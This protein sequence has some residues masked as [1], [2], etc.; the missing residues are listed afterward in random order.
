MAIS[1]SNLYSMLVATSNQINIVSGGGGGGSLPTFRN[2]IINGD[3]RIDQRNCG[4]A[5][6]ITQDGVYD[7]PDR[8]MAV[9]NTYSSSPSYTFQQ[10]TLSATDMNTLG[11]ITNSVRLT[12]TNGNT[13][14]NS[15]GMVGMQYILEGFYIKDLN[16]GTV[17]GNNISVN[18][19]MKTNVIGNHN[20]ALTNN[21]KNTSYVATFNVGVSNTW[22]NVKFTVPAPPSTSDWDTSSNVG[23]RL[24]I[25]ATCLGYLTGNSNTWRN[26]E[27]NLT[28]SN[29][30]SS[31]WLTS[32]NYVEITG[33][34]LEIGSNMTP[35]EIRPLPIELGLCRRYFEKNFPF[36]TLPTSSQSNT[37]PGDCMYFANLTGMGYVSF[38]DPKCTIPTIDF[39]NPY[40]NVGNVRNSAGSNYT[41]LANQISTVGVGVRT[42]DSGLNNSLGIFNWK[43]NCE[44]K[45]YD[46]NPS[47]GKVSWIA[48]LQSSDAGGDQ[49]TTVCSTSDGGI[50]AAGYYNSTYTLT[51]Y[52]AN[53]TT[54]AT[55]LIASS[56]GWDPFLV[57]YSS[58]GTIQWIAKLQSSITGVDRIIAICST[59]DGGIV[60]AGFYDSTG[61]LTAY[62]ANLTAFTT[63]LPASSTGNDPFLVKYSSSGTVQWIAK[64]QTSSNNEAQFSG[65]CST[66]DGGIVASGFYDSTS[67]LTA[68][69]ATLTTFATI[70]PASATANDPFLVKYSS[71][72]TVQWIAKLQSSAGGSGDR[73]N[74][75]CSTSDGGIIAAG[76]YFTNGSLTAYNANLT[77]FATILP[78]SSTGQDPCLVKYSSS[79]TVQWIAKLQ[80]SSTGTDQILSIC[81]TSDGGVVA[82]GFYASSD[83]FTA[84][85]ANLTTFATI[86]PASSTG[87]DPFLV[88]YSSSGTVLW[89]AKLQSSSTGMDHIQSI[90]PTLDGG[91]VAAG[92]YDS[93]G[94]LTAYN[95]NLTAFTTILPASSNDTDPFL[96]KYSS[97]GTV[98]WIAKLQSSSTG[99]DQILGICSTSDGGIVAAGYYN[100]TGTLTAYDATGNAFGMVL[101]SSSTDTDPFIVKYTDLAPAQPVCKWVSQ[102][103]GTGNDYVQS[104]ANV[105]AAPDGAVVAAGY[106][107]S[108]PLTF[109]NADTTSFATTLANSGTSDV[110]LVKYNYYGQILWVTRIASSGDDVCYSVS[111]LNDNSIIV[112]GA[113]RGTLTAYNA[114]GS[115][116]LTTLTYSGSNSDSFIAKYDSDGYVQ[117][118]AKIAGSA[119]ETIYDISIDLT[120]NIYVVGNAA[121][122]T[123]TAYNADGTSFATTISNP[124]AGTRT[125]CFIVKYTNTGTV[126]WIAK[127]G[128]SSSFDTYILGS[129]VLLDNSLIVVGSQGPSGSLTAYNA[130]S[131]TFAT[132]FTNTGSIDGYICNYNSS[133]IVQ[134]IA[135]I[136]GTGDEI[137]KYVCTL[138]D[139]GIVVTGT[140]TTTLT[141]YNATGTAFAT[142]LTN[143]GSTDVFIIKYNSSGVVQWTTKLTGTLG[144]D[145]TNITSATDGGFVVSGFFASTS[146]SLYNANN[147]L[148][149]TSLTNTGTNAGYAIKF[150]T[151][152]TI[153]GITNFSGGGTEQ[154]TA[155]GNGV[156]DG[157]TIIGGTFTSTNYLPYGGTYTLTNKGGTDSFVGRY[158]LNVLSYP[159]ASGSVQWI[160]KLQ[161]STVSAD[162]ITGV[163]ST[164]DGGIVAVGNY[165]SSTSLTVYNAD[166][167]TFGTILNISST[168]FDTFLVKYSSS[169]I[170]QWIAKLQSSG[171]G[172][173]QF[174]CICSTNDGGICAGGYYNSNSNTLIA[175]N[176]NLT[177]FSTILSS[178]NTGND[179]FLV[180]YS[181]SGNVQWIAKL[182]SSISSSDQILAICSTNDGGI[183]TGGFYDSSNALTAYHANL[184]AFATILPASS[185]NYD[186]FL[187]KYS[188]TGTVQWISKLQTSGSVED[189]IQAICSTNDGGIVVS[190]YYNS[191]STLTAYNA[192]LTTFATILPVSSTDYDPFL[193]KYSSTGTVQWI[194]KLQSS[195][196]VD[197]RI[198]G[199]C[200]TSDGGIVAAGFYTASATLTAYNA[201]L[202]TF[203]TI[204][205]ASSTG[206]DPFLVKYSSSGTVQWIAKL[207]SSS[208]GADQIIGICSTNDG[209]FIAAG[210][211]DS[212]DTFTA[213]NANLTTF[214]TILSASTSGFNPFLVKYSF[215]GTVQWIAKLQSSSTGDDRFTSICS[216]FDGGVV[217]AGSYD[218]TG[219]LTAYNANL[220]AFA[221][222]LP[223]SSTSSDSFLVKYYI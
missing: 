180:K 177:T 117:W 185:T 59:S 168:G 46:P 69:N 33:L 218:S 194:S 215:S 160:A 222:I 132:V 174:N 84:Y 56:T 83:T 22:S 76:F 13:I 141:A 29:Y 219:T 60:A 79:G 145:V 27:F 63:I 155:L 24:D 133:G 51:A 106:Y 26:G 77:T 178:S 138:S 32:N 58:S 38:K 85:N 34:Q 121:S 188:S 23:I 110:F 57:K 208:T 130:D 175:Y 166:L 140:Y 17:N 53:L 148:Y 36:D 189:R 183:I 154:I 25:D 204:L 44:Y 6:T 86:L 152:G 173:D 64:L 43:A 100:S 21:A 200:S 167:T 114:V 146:L 216:T 198:F 80:S 47:V 5:V 195:S 40:S 14:V 111:C 7:G 10:Q 62:N 126:L 18:M 61:T 94:T 127:L 55:I 209:G 41:I 153:Q 199:I 156:L 211:Y 142:T 125:Q 92:F 139:G 39:Y 123:T 9:I 184:T 217:A 65:I 70:L 151:F 197:D 19:W 101:P 159:P 49:F 15:Y 42:N 11:G 191:S 161:T 149:S 192:N 179:P 8:I 66:S 220:T 190:G 122:T 129:C 99:G 45:K 73:N 170:V 116:F 54:F 131:S 157:S 164:S 165:N 67:S 68:Y 102:I 147:T 93:T 119:D 196:I 30:L 118:I 71:S 158:A 201:N 4:T 28:S 137:A 35:F 214:A 12:A 193:V 90:C 75:I 163:C 206:F 72:G 112:T 202:T 120:N 115:S 105:P 96:I 162:V 134:W 128:N 113:Y 50:V 221:T 186:S 181:S 223:S 169:G 207:Q 89:I 74:C 103:G 87:N 95:A 171:S 135:K 205:P 88:K 37:A 176:A 172:N 144:D 16:W 98:Q 78:A 136:G 109:Y 187:V 210:F 107:T 31:L 108:N 143:S 82:A 20:I 91:I 124:L 1:F 182:Q 97:A 3:M 2:K 213:Y 150:N 212:T 48:K 203:A 81:S 52:N 104:V